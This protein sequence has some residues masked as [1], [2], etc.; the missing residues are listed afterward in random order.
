MQF[1]KWCCKVTRQKFRPKSSKGS[2]KKKFLAEFWLIFTKNRQKRGRRKFVYCI[3]KS[4]LSQLSQLKIRNIFWI[5]SAAPFLPV[6]GKNQPKFG[7]KFFF[8]GPFWAFWPKFLP[9]NLATPFPELKFSVICLSGVCVSPLWPSETGFG[10][11]PRPARTH[12][13]LR[14]PA[15]RAGTAAG[16]FTCRTGTAAGRFTC[17]TGTAAG[18]FTCR[19]VTAGRG[20][21]GWELWSPSVTQYTLQYTAEESPTKWR[22]SV[23][24][25][26]CWELR[27][28]PR[29]PPPVTEPWLY[30]DCWRGFKPLVPSD[31]RF[32][33]S[34]VWC[35]FISSSTTTVYAVQPYRYRYSTLLYYSLASI[36][37]IA[38]IDI[39]R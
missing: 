13:E 28:C 15:G 35:T 2:T 16:R 33:H 6:F 26:F 14:I 25:E 32:N 38:S 21:G 31:K 8:F 4:N 37:S 36:A 12:W 5:F 18:R 10:P 11:P 39:F 17:R 19:T 22:L 27:C 23:V 29:Q 30:T 34:K 7:Q 1:R 20:G 24:S 3:L 9:G